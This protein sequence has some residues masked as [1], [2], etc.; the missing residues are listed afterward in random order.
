M[1]R[2]P[3]ELLQ[4]GL[5]AAF[6]AGPGMGTGKSAE[7]LLREVLDANVPLVLDADALNLIASSKTL[8]AR[9]P[10]RSAASVL[11]PHPAEAAR[12]LGCGTAEVQSDRV[13][14][15][16]EIAARYGAVV[17]LKGNGS[18]IAGPDGSWLINSTGNP[19][20]ASA[21]MGDVLTGMIASLLAQ[22]A[23]ARDAAAAAVWLHG[24]AGD[25]LAQ[26]G[27]GPIGICAGEIIESARALLNAAL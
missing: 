3:R 14:A 18:I 9:L 26:A 13:K 2:T 25:A 23:N 17:V 10:K 11:T 27:N 19:G 21:G 4:P 5:I 1:L 16:L 6:A 22:G 12:L 7:Q 24:A 20:M 15:A 8:Q